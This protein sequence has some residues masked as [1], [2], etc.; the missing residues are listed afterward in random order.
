M[1]KALLRGCLGRMGR[2][3][4]ELQDADFAIV[5]GV[6]T[7]A[8]GN[9]GYPVYASP[10]ECAE[11][12]GVAIDFSSPEGLDIMLDYCIRRDVPLVLGT[13]GLDK[14]AQNYVRVAAQRVA[15]L[16]AGNFSFGVSVL[17]KLAAAAAEILCEDC[18][19][20]ITERHHRQKR[21]APS[22]T[23]Y[24][25]LD[26][27]AAALPYEPVPVFGRCGPAS[28]REAREI[29][30]HAL[31]GGSIVGEHEV[32]FAC[33]G[34]TLTLTHTAVSRELFAAGALRAARFIVTQEPGLYGMKDLCSFAV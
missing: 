2:A 9:C 25:L 3:V 16:Q 14:T 13:T 27:I 22:G 33:A 21:D 17:A 11:K 18:D 1:L 29:G 15:V 20:E 8:P 12:P 30:V 24:M 28:G 5:A 34:E 26:A 10:F 23:A 31:R 7:G 4:S 6:D 32:T 19:I